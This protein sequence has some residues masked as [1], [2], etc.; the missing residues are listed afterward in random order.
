MVFKKPPTPRHDKKAVSV[1]NVTCASMG[2]IPVYSE[3]FPTATATIRGKSGLG[4]LD[5]SHLR[6]L[7]ANPYF[8]VIRAGWQSGT[9]VIEFQTLK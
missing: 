6:L 9:I 3:I 8:A 1:I 2:V 4:S 5:S 7:S